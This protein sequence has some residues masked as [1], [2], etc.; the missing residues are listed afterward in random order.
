MLGV[1]GRE[2]RPGPGV[3]HPGAGRA[4]VDG[5]LVR[6][7]AVEIAH[8]MLAGVFAADL[9]E[10]DRGVAV[11]VEIVIVHQPGIGFGRHRLFGQGER[12]AG[13][14]LVGGQ[15]LD[16]LVAD[17]GVGGAAVEPAVDDARV[18]PG[19]PRRRDRPDAALLKNGIGQVAGILRIG[20]R[21]GAL[22]GERGMGVVERRAVS[23]G[24]KVAVPVGTVADRGGRR[25]AVAPPAD[26]AVVVGRPAAADDRPAPEL[27]LARVGGIV[28]G[29]GGSLLV[30]PPGGPAVRGEVIVPHLLGQGGAVVSRLRIAHR[31][32]DALPPGDGR[33]GGPLVVDDLL[34]DRVQGR[35]VGAV[36]GDPADIDLG[37]EIDAA[38]SH[39]HRPLAEVAVGVLVPV[40]GEVGVEMI[41]GRILVGTAAQP[42][43]AHLHGHVALAAL[44]GRG[45]ADEEDVFDPQGE[46]I[47]LEPLADLFGLVVRRLAGHGAPGRFGDD[48]DGVVHV[49]LMGDEGR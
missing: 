32:E 1:A 14:V 26:D 27:F 35:I 9:L 18:E 29:E 33:G 21:A 31:Q 44:I 25:A 10:R 8:G 49:L 13:V 28:G 45:V 43:P 48:I 5:R 41:R 4:E 7:V 47:R 46:V 37:R 42:W 34:E 24:E 30:L 17:A 38:R 6:A 2:L 23:I 40:A 22:V 16:V 12:L 19:D 36:D 11:E 15:A 3:P 20:V 39:V